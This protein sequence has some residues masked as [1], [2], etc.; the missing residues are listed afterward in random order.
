MI[1]YIDLLHKMFLKIFFKWHILL[2]RLKTTP[3]SIRPTNK[4]LTHN[5]IVRKKY[6]EFWG[7]T[8]YGKSTTKMGHFSQ[9]AR[10]RDHGEKEG[11]PAR[12]RYGWHLSCYG[13][14]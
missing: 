4:M 6:I 5:G 3:T 8:N 12:K 7:K 9:K 13:M 2:S 1:W 14:T 10:K 11:F